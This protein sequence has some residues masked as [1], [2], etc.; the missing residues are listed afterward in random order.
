M[1]APANASN[2][3]VSTDVSAKTVSVSANTQASAPAQTAAAVSL[4]NSA[5][6][7][8]MSARILGLFGE[9][10]NL[11]PAQNNA[12]LTAN[13]PAGEKAMMQRPAPINLAFVQAGLNQTAVLTGM[14][15]EKLVIN[16]QQNFAPV[17][18]AK[19]FGGLI[20][21]EAVPREAKAATQ[22]IISFAE[23]SRIAHERDVQK[24][25]LSK[26]IN[27][28]FGKIMHKEEDDEDLEGM[29]SIWRDYLERQREQKDQRE[30]EER[31]KKK[32]KRDAERQEEELEP[33]MAV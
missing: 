29:Y 26:L 6:T 33:V 20:F 27:L 24:E 11:N 18:A 9:A 30:K 4:F 16:G 25:N 28:L 15:G 5:A 10:K 14:N 32:Q 21:G 31:R 2:I 22:P 13:L 3:A 23:L 1:T 12:A 19:E 7:G 8:G 17:A